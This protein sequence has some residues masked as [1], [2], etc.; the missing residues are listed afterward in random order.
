MASPTTYVALLRAVNVAGRNRVSMADLRALVSGLGME[1]PRTLLQSGNLVFR[2]GI[3]SRARI[4]ALLEEAAAAELG[5][6][7][8][9]LVRTAADWKDIIAENPF[10][11]EASRD[12]G[13]LIAMFLKAA[14]SADRVAALQAAIKGREIVRAVRETAFITYPNGIGRSK[15]TVAVIERMLGTR[16][17]GR[18]WNTVLKLETSIQREE[19]RLERGRNGSPSAAGE[20]PG[21]SNLG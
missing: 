7:T 21:A 13:H 15:L 9:F 14:P 5:L 6:S 20:G 19:T 3:G 10:P 17:T 2:S 4:T 18:N 12:P 1:D 8:D 16:G 11:E